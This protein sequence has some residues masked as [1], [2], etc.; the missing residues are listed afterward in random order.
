[1]LG[2]GGNTQTFLPRLL[3]TS[4]PAVSIS[5]FFVIFQTSLDA[6]AS[7]VT[8]AHTPVVCCSLAAA[9]WY[10]HRHCLLVPIAY[11]GLR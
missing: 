4:V 5:Y 8:H 9:A 6:A 1:M 2:S 11:K 7:T 3:N 10:L